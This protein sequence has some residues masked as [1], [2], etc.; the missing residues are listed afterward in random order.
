MN[1]NFPQI[2]ISNNSNSNLTNYFSIF[3]KLDA[4]FCHLLL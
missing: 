1:K 3:S 2:D 4:V